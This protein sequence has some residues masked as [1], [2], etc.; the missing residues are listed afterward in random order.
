[1]ETGRNT[2]APKLTDSGGAYQLEWEEQ[3]IRI[4]VDRLIDSRGHT[5]GEIRVQHK[6]A[7]GSK[8]LHMHL[9]RLNLTSTR[10]RSQLATSLSQHSNGAIKM[11][12]KT[13]L[14][15]T[16]VAVL[17]KHREGEPVR[18]VGNQP[19]QEP[20]RYR[21]SPILLEGQPNMIYG[22]GGT[23]KT[24]L[25]VLLALQVQAG[26]GFLGMRPIEG[27]V[28]WL[29]YETSAEEING[30]VKRLKDGMALEPDIEIAYRYCSQPVADDIVAIQR[31]VNETQA[32]L[33]VIDSVGT[34]CGGEPEAAD[35][36]LKYFLALR[37]LRVT[38]LS[39]DHVAKE[40]RE[41][42]GNRGPF[43]SVYKWNACRNI[44]EALK[45]S[46]DN[47]HLVVGLHHRKINAGPLLKPLGFKFTFEP[48]SIL[49]EKTDARQI[50]E[51]LAGMGL[52]DQIEAALLK[53]A[54][55]P[56][57][58]ADELGSKS[59]TVSTT[60]WRHKDRFVNLGS[61]KWGVKTH[62]EVNV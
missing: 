36:V 25:A 44:W 37:S 8:Y 56:A 45:S 54:M 62:S 26:Q 23:G 18:K 55:T 48:D 22:P 15:W 28:L 32:Q 49:P 38:T 29:D 58:L 46:S 14:E 21:L 51:V 61:G 53:Q 60:L 30:I 24:T 7:G 11:D 9:A 13:A 5:S 16:C 57:E 12:W 4:C 34:A 27:P 6:P 2:P 10:E 35:V 40:N 19:R 31:M 1:M 41:N 3:G 43:G 20:N 59:G 52:A 33:V 42:R 39:L 47:G 17:S 50:P